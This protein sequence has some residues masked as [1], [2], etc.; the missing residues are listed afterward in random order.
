MKNDI[1]KTDQI[2][3]REYAKLSESD[4]YTIQELNIQDIDRL[5]SFSMKHDDIFGDREYIIWKYLK[6]P[7]GNPRIF[8]AVVN[9]EIKG[10]LCY[11]PRY[12]YTV[13]SDKIL[14]MQAVD[15]FLAPEVRGKS[16]YSRLLNLSQNKI[17]EPKY[18]FPNKKAEIA[19][20]KS[21]WELISPVS[22]WLFP[23][24]LGD[25]FY[26]SRYHLIRL[27]VNRILKIYTIIC[28]K[29][30]QVTLHKT[31]KIL[32]DINGW[33]FLGRMHGSRSPEYLNWRF[34]EN[35][36]GYECIEFID[37][38]EMIGY[39]MYTRKDRIINIY[40]FVVSRKIRGAMKA[41][42]ERARS[43]DVLSIF[44]NIINVDLWK[45]GFI[46]K[47]RASSN[48]LGYKFPI[49]KLVM[50]YCDSDWDI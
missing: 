23:V 28:L 40:D 3:N 1:K 46:K 2:L 10:A 35:P 38:T 22:T 44:F 32:T 16:L 45:L 11:I 47:R 20:L 27:M 17:S 4:S 8:I 18:T 39:C 13:N 37:E 19:E 49:K 26:G 30:E 5:I 31:P 36:R 12:F 48:L 34:I 14:M 24:N 15:A 9:K 42:V 50:T 25:I 7:A 29:D 33:P 6:N 43:E 21:G 41:F